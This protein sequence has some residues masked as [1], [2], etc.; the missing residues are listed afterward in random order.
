MSSHGHKSDYIEFEIDPDS[1]L[2]PSLEIQK[3]TF[4]ALFPV[5]TNQITLIYSLRQTDPEAAAS[6][7]RS[8]EQLLTV[9]RQDIYDYIPKTQYDAIIA[10]KPS[11][12][13]PAPATPKEQPKVSVSIKADANTMAGQELLKDVGVEPANEGPEVGGEG[14]PEAPNPGEPIPAG[15]VPRPQSPMG[16][17]VDASVGRAANLPFF[18]GQ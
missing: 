1:M 5:V 10:L 3:Q 15:N 17:A 9:Q 6:Q 16:S 12:N 18:P 13:L 4:M 8:L 7:L 11:E 2:L 14:L